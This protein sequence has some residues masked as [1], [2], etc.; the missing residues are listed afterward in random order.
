MPVGVYKRSEKQ[1][2]F[3]KEMSNRPKPLRGGGYGAIH[4]WLY[5]HY[6]KA[7]QCDNPFC[8]KKSKTYQWA[9]RKEFKYEHKRENF[10]QLCASCHRRY[11][12]TLEKR[13]K[14]GKAKLGI[15]NTKE[16]NQKISLSCKGIH[17][18]NKHS[19]KRIIQTSLD[20]NVIKIWDCIADAA[21]HLGIM[22][23]GII[24]C[25]RGGIKKCG[26]FKWTY[27]DD[28]K[29]NLFTKKCLLC[30]REFTM[31]LKK[32]I[33]CSVSCQSK[34]KGKAYKDLLIKNKKLIK[35]IHALI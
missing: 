34:S 16:H 8:T 33:Y 11:D 7:T 3:L 28:Q 35:E 29:I 17:K 23:S 24:M 9:K 30:M 2:K 15:K 32:Q 18:G 22:S 21:K 13:I 20:G 26:K 27:V 19:A 14:A 4:K 25:A 5:K 12:D 10:I 6:G 1:I 31:G